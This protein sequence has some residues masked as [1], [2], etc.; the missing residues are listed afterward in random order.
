MFM[1]SVY[2]LFYDRIKNKQLMELILVIT[3]HYFLL[4]FKIKILKLKS[5]NLIYYDLLT[6]CLMDKKCLSVGKEVLQA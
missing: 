2:L 6:F 4:K 5:Y 1:E 3:S